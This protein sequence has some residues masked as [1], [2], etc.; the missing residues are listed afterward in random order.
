M[1]NFKE[2]ENVLR[3][4]FGDDLIECVI[5]DSWNSVNDL[6]DFFD[7]DEH[8]TRVSKRSAILSAKVLGK[9]SNFFSEYI[10]LQHEKVISYY[11][12]NRELY[13]CS[14]HDLIELAMNNNE[15]KFED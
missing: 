4:V 5:N 3:E 2:H 6:T 9:L 1:N 14:D 11:E 12:N 15:F 10:N 7:E 8:T 13:S